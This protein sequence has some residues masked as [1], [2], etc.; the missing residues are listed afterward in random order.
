VIGARLNLGFGM[1]SSYIGDVIKPMILSR[2]EARYRPGRSIMMDP[3][4]ALEIID[5]AA[6]LRRTGSEKPGLLDEA[7]VLR[8]LS[9]IL[10]DITADT[11]TPATVGALAAL[12]PASMPSVS[13]SP[14]LGV[15]VKGIGKFIAIGSTTR[16]TPRKPNCPFP[17]SRRCS[18]S[19][20]CSADPTTT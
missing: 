17:R 20:Q 12:D 13:G 6:S 5:E 1:V 15:P 9:S 8:D 14:R 4:L 7:G 16:T 10:D 11:V 3:F 2:S 19:H 18:P